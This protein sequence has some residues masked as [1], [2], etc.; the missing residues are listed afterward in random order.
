MESEILVKRFWIGI[1]LLSISFL[2]PL[3]VAYL[4]QG[5]YE[6][7]DFLPRKHFTAEDKEDLLTVVKKNPR[8]LYYPGLSVQQG[9]GFLLELS[10]LQ[11]FSPFP[12]QNV[13]NFVLR[14]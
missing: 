14:C 10:F 5:Y 9:L 8:I 6:D 4:Y 13:K 7:I 3:N 2:I 11:I 12:P 1:F